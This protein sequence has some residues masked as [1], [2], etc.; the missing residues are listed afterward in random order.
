M[1]VWSDG[2]LS[3]RSAAR[4]AHACTRS[5][6]AAL[7]LM[8]ARSV[9]T[10]PAPRL[11]PR[12]ARRSPLLLLLGALGLDTRGRREHSVGPRQAPSK[13]EPAIDVSSAPPSAP[14]GGARSVPQAQDDLAAK[15]QT[16][17]AASAG[18][19]SDRQVARRT[20]WVCAPSLKCGWSVRH[21]LRLPDLS[22]ATASDASRAPESSCARRKTC[23][24]ATRAWWSRLSDGTSGRRS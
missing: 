9:R 24:K 2:R 1:V 17:K 15:E 14:V 18:G 23:P 21:V 5:A 10:F 4:R 8:T 20:R 11:P 13:T 6:R 12:P 22:T 16:A 19:G 7:P 3:P